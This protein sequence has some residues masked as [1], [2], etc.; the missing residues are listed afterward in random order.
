MNTLFS[1]WK[2]SRAAFVDSNLFHYFF[3][4]TQLLQINFEIELAK[5]YIENAD[6]G[7][8][9]MLAN[10]FKQRLPLI[11]AEREALE[12]DLEFLESKGKLK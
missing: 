9:D 5:K 3:F 7:G 1:I 12:A 2:I 4:K 8:T 10:Y 11:T 6:K